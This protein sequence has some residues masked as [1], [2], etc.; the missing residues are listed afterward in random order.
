MTLQSCV[1]RR[2]F[3]L[4]ELLVVIAIIALLIGILLPALGT[5]RKTAWSL[6]DQTQ[7]RSIGTGQ[8]VYMTDNDDF[9]AAANTSGWEA[10]LQASRGNQTFLTGSTNS[11]TPTQVFDFISPTLGQDLG[12][13]NI[14]ANRV[15]NI[16]NDFRDPAA[17]VLINEIW[18]GSDGADIEDF[19][20]YV[21]NNRG[22][23][24]SSYHM[25]GAFQYWGSLRSGFTPGQPGG[26]ETSTLRSR[27][28][29]VPRIW[30]GA[31]STQVKTPRGYRNRIEQVGISPSTKIMSAN[32]TRFV[33]DNTRILD[34]DASPLAGTHGMFSTGTPQFVEERSYGQSSRAGPLNLE[35]TFRHKNN[36][37]N[38]VFFDGHTEN[39]T[40]ETVWTEMDKW[41]PSGSVVVDQSRLTQEAR[42]WLQDLPDGTS[43]TGQSGKRLP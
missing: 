39:L 27:Y 21:V 31:I 7:Q 5:A 15:G 43:G 20:E 42:V 14:R 8:A 29:F 25:P 36:T 26:D 12:F 30:A 33:T 11:T 9:F 37:I 35:L 13:S 41:A 2:G 3:T 34:I 40:Q 28:G 16:F 6:V 19:E 10:Q 1:R 23:F 24:Q 4:I 32:A 18:T 17:R 22:Y 38:A